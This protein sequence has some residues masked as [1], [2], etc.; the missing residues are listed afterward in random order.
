MAA[1]RDGQLFCVYR[2]RGG[3]RQGMVGCMCVCCLVILKS[4]PYLIPS[5]DF[6]FCGDNFG[7]DAPESP[8]LVTCK[9]WQRARV[10]RVSDWS[11]D[12]PSRFFVFAH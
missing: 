6:C 4:G 7:P 1:G 10:L 2:I 12:R 3:V 9:L 8:N 11:W 5:G